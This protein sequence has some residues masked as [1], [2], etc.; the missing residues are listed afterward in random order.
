MG[1]RVIPAIAEQR[2]TVCDACGTESENARPDG[3]LRLFRFG[4][5]KLRRYGVT[6]DFCSVG[7]LLRVVP[8]REDLAVPAHELVGGRV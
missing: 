1:E 6:L 3:W 5:D 7:C 4:A 2:F 8:A